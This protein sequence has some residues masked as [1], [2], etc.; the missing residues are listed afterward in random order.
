MER[1][2]LGPSG[3]NPVAED[4]FRKGFELSKSGNIE[5][6]IL[7]VEAA[8]AVSPDEGR[9][10]DLMGTLYAKKGLYE[11]A[12][13]EWKRSIECDP[14]HAEIFRRIENAEKLKAQIPPRS[15]RL[16]W[17]AM[18]VVS[19]LFV[20]SLAWGVFQF[21]NQGAIKTR[22]AEK[23]AELSSVEENYVTK[24]DHQKIVDMSEEL[25]SQVNSLENEVTSRNEEIAGLKDESKFV[26]QERL[27]EETE[28]RYQAE[29]DLKLARE[30]INKLKVQLQAVGDA[31]GAEALTE[32]IEMKD[33]ELSELSS[34]YKNLNDDRL[35]LE[36]E[37]ETA[38]TKVV[39]LEAQVDDLQAQFAM[40]GTSTL[41]IASVSG[42]T[43]LGPILE[44]T[45][46]AVVELHSGNRDGALA[47]LRGLEEKHPNAP[48]LKEAIQVLTP[49][50]EEVTVDPTATLEPTQAPTKA[51]TP[52]PTATKRPTAR[53]ISTPVP[54][55]SGPITPAKP[56]PVGGSSRSV[57]ESPRP[58]PQQ[59]PVKA[60]PRVNQTERLQKQ[61]AG[62]TQQAYQA[63]QNRDFARAKQL[64]DRA[65]RIDPKDP[66]VNQLRGAIGRAMG[67]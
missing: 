16:V 45:L 59:E 15:D 60:P 18:G 7:A 67:Q 12:V 52:R 49:E 43:F 51:P 33:E 31:T 10:H 20:L 61:K 5:E 50:E 8:I 57:A 17:I 55:R 6:G 23:E 47:S 19:L 39:G 58:Q 32:R 35:R 4:Q 30:D 25:S 29:G 28:R 40:S 24:A 26:P 65:Y 3:S 48:G 66:A 54:T 44:S 38:R 22:L 34:N 56:R 14:D 63:Y 11:M 42:E 53:P 36:H 21:R 37:L 64:V 62:F 2:S 9:Y 27:Q 13:A 1:K 41:Q 46:K